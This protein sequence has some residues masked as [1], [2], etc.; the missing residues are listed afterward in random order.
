ML[1]VGGRHDAV[2]PGRLG[3]EIYLNPSQSGEALLFELASASTEKNLD[4][5]RQTFEVDEREVGVGEMQNMK[6]EPEGQIVLPQ[7]AHSLE[8]KGEVLDIG[9][10]GEELGREEAQ[11]CSG[12]QVNSEV[13]KPSTEGAAEEEGESWMSQ[14]EGVR[15]V[16]GREVV[17]VR[18][19]PVEVLGSVEVVIEQSKGAYG[20]D[21]VDEVLG[22][23]R[24][25][26]DGDPLELWRDLCWTEEDELADH[27]LKQRKRL[28]FDQRRNERHQRFQTP[29]L[30]VLEPLFE[31]FARV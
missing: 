16:K 30:L 4:E 14:R 6:I 12:R 1:D 31:H 15:D 17:E 29:S 11:W 21:V 10:L 9:D 13:L 5:R 26:E 19:D 25:T 3:H 23:D 18:V 22:E 24:M 20:S 8:R 2:L 7:T 27:A 28:Q